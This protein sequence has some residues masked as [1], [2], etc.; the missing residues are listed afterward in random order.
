MRVAVVLEKNEGGCWR[1]ERGDGLITT[2]PLQAPPITWLS[3]VECAKPFAIEPGLGRL[4]SGIQ[5][6]S[7][8]WHTSSP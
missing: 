5:L 8:L 6:A 3:K 7:P 4:P 1:G 2:T